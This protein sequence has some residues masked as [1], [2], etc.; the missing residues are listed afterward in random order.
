MKIPTRQRNSDQ[1]IL[2][3]IQQQLTRQDSQHI[4][5]HATNLALQA[6]FGFSQVIHA[7]LELAFDATVPKFLGLLEHIFLVDGTTGRRRVGIR[8]PHKKF[9]EVASSAF[10]GKISVVCGC[11]KA[12]SLRGPSKGVANGVCQALKVVRVEVHLVADNVVVGWASRALQ[13]AMSLEEKVVF[14]DSSD[15]TVN[16][17]ARFG[18]PVMIC[19]GGFRGIEPGVV[20]L[21]TNNH[22]QFWA[23]RTLR[24]IKFPEGCSNLGNFVV[25]DNGELTLNRR[26][27]RRSTEKN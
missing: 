5:E 11:S 1:N 18:V 25:N 24:R 4:P 17:C 16:D 2:R 7:F 6:F 9:V 26:R 22:R 20:P 3:Y 13:T 14:I 23:I 15:T 8:E 10:A 21:A 27:I 19:T 12:N